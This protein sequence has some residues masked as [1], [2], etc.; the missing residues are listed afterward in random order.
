VGAELA[1]EL[2]EPAVDQAVGDQRRGDLAPQAVLADLR[3]E[4]L[5]QHAREV[6]E[7]AVEQVGLV[8]QV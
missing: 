4:A 1:H 5:A 3:A 6:L 7:E 8:R 2:A